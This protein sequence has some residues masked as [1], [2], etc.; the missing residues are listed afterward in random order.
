MDGSLDE[1]ADSKSTRTA[2]LINADV[3]PGIEVTE[4]NIV[5]STQSS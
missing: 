2:L 4:K 5:T 1:Q 3:I